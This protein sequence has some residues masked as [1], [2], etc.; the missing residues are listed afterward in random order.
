MFVF[1]FSSGKVDKRSEY[2][3]ILVPEFCIWHKFP[4]VYWLKAMMLPTILYRFNQLLLAEDLLVKLNSLCNISV[5]HNSN[6]K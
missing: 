2:I 1:R 5:D 3:E 6:S 4:S